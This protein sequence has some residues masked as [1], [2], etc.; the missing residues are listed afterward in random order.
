MN[1]RQRYLGRK[2]ADRAAED[3]IR[4]PEALLELMTQWEIYPEHEMARAIANLG[5]ACSQLRA[6]YA[7]APQCKTWALE[8]LINSIDQYRRRAL[9]KQSDLLLDECDEAIVEDAL[10]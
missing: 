4:K 2:M 6:I 9:T 1:D 10:P 3:E 5:D 7:A 8:A